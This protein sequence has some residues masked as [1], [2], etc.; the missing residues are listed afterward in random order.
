LLEETMTGCVMSRAK[1]WGRELVGVC[2]TI[3]I[4]VMITMP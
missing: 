1:S 4:R 3:D 2:W